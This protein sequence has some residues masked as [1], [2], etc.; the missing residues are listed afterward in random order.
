ML[1]LI[2][3]DAF[4]GGARL[5]LTSTECRLLH[6]FLNS[7]GTVVSHDFLAKSIWGDAWIAPR[8]SRSTSSG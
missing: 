3:Y 1:D 5:T 8:W 4:L 6:L 7:L 2:T